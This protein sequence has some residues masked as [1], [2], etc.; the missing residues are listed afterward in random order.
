MNVKSNMFKNAIDVMSCAIINVCD[1]QMKEMYYDEDEYNNN[2]NYEQ[3]FMMFRKSMIEDDAD[4]VNLIVYEMNDILNKRIDELYE[5]EVDNDDVLISN[6]RLI[7]YRKQIRFSSRNPSIIR[8]FLGMLET[9]KKSAGE[10][11]AFL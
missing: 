9:K 6:C 8:L 10:T 2:D 5:I 4:F 3:E 11:G 7:S 1:Q